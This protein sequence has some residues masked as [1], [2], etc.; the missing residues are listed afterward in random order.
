MNNILIKLVNW[1]A[2]PM[3]QYHFLEKKKKEEG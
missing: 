2:E 3:S 1:K